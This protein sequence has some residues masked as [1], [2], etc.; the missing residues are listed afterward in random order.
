M[1]SKAQPAFPEPEQQRTPSE[2]RDPASLEWPRGYPEHRE[3]D[4]LWEHF[5]H[6]P[7]L[8][9]EQYETLLHAMVNVLF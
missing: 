4:Y 2:V 8:G 3:P 1:K 7:T 6:E 5:V 9:P